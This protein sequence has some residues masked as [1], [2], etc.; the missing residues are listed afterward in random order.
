MQRKIFWE[1]HQGDTLQMLQHTF[2]A[3]SP[4]SVYAKH[5][6]RCTA[7]P[8]PYIQRQLLVL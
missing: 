4:A 5:F 2:P 3:Q 6:I 8:H 1:Y 7:G